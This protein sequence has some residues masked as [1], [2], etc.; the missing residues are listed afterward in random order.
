MTSRIISDIESL[1]AEYPQQKK[2]LEDGLRQ[3]YRIQYGHGTSYLGGQPTVEQWPT[4]RGCPMV[5][6]GKIELPSQSNLPYTSGSLLF[7]WAQGT[8]GDWPKEQDACKVIYQP[9]GDTIPELEF[10]PQMPDSN[11][12]HRLDVQLTETVMLPDYDDEDLWGEQASEAQVEVANKLRDQYHIF[13]DHRLLGN[14]SYVHNA[15]AWNCPRPEDVSPLNGSEDL[16]AAPE[17]WRLLAQFQSDR[18]WGA[19]FSD[20]GL[21]YYC[22]R[23]QDLATGRL[24]RVFALIQG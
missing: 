16:R 13:P 8:W 21:L 23:E 4:Y 18:Q 9:A 15:V 17:Q 11:K 22:I 1:F 5:F 14:P 20:A 6:I 2:M 7:F 24:D 10:P 19:N 12:L 3:G